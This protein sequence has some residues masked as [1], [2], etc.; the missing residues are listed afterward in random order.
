[1]V[2]TQREFH[3]LV[4]QVNA[5]FTRLEKRVDELEKAKPEPKQEAKKSK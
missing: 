3:S 5:A 1:M 4:E 2:V